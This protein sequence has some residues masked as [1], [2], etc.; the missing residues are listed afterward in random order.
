MDVKKAARKKQS[1]A[2]GKFTRIC[3]VFTAASMKDEPT[4]S[5][6]E[7]LKELERAYE[8]LEDKH[9]QYIDILDSDDETDSA[10]ISTEYGDYIQETSG[11]SINRHNI[12]RAQQQRR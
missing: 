12:K 7:S 6:K 8:D 2:K 5:L 1:T 4:R 11:C 10:A 3:N 9:T